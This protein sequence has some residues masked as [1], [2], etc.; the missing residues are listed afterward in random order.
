MHLP[1]GS[2]WLCSYFSRSVHTVYL[3]LPHNKE[4]VLCHL[5]EDEAIFLVFSVADAAINNR[6]KHRQCA[7]MYG[8][9]DQDA[10]RR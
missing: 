10:E 4:F 2:S 7:S 6:K 9:Q 3:P 1:L 5:E 8:S